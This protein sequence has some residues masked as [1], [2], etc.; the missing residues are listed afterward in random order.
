MG[1]LSA[2]NDTRIGVICNPNAGHLLRRPELPS[3]LR[4]LLGDE[5]EVVVTE[6]VAD[7]PAAV[8]HFRREKVALV[9]SCGGDGTSV[10]TL[11]ELVRNA[12]SELPVLAFLPGGTVNTIAR[13]LGVTGSPRAA[14]ARLVTRLR[15]R[16][17]LP[18][19][20]HDVLKVG[21]R[22]GFLFAAAMGARFLQEYYQRTPGPLSAAGLGLHT[23][24]SCLFR[25]RLAQRLFAPT[26][27]EIVIDG[28]S[29][30]TVI[31]P[32]YVVAATIA[33]VGLGMRVAWRAGSLPGRMHLIASE[34]S[35]AN[36]ALQLHKTISGRPLTGE[37]HLDRL[38]SQVELR[39]AEPQVYTLDGELY[40]A[41]TVSI[42]MGPRLQIL[43]F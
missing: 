7:V 24:G 41:R 13:N 5:G 34:L 21:E 1:N 27:M 39:F 38:A 4:A 30:H 23:V 42:G 19:A 9:A 2:L 8:A 37:R 35:T 15:R 26:P 28:K 33:D 10:C 11:T 16:D 18:I 20:Q 25:G 3:E 14:F 43:R 40:T 22:Y 12:G 6:S 29:D 32:R 17:A 36:M 31:A